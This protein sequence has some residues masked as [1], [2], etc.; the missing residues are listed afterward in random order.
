MALAG[1]FDLNL[2]LT[3]P[4]H[5]CGRVTLPQ[6][7]LIL[8]FLFG[9]PGIGVFLLAYMHTGKKKKRRKVATT[10]SIT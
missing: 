4:V 8:F 2:A 10:S 7:A 5:P 1:K 9:V 6:I 3:E